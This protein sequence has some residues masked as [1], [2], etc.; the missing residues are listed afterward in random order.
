M[1]IMSNALQCV[2]SYQQLQT[3][4]MRGVAGPADEGSIQKLLAR[5]DGLEH[6]KCKDMQSIVRRLQLPD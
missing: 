2:W 6:L 3:R 5:E 4:I 1:S